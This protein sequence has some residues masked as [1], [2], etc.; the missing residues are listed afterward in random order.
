VRII[1]TDNFGGDYPDE[2]FLNLPQMTKEHAD[3]VC[4]AINAGF[5]TDCSRHWRTVAN[6]YKLVPG[7]EP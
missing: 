5:P 6:D 1:E 2:K 3:A 7:F 4:K